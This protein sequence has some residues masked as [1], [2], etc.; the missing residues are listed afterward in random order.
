[1]HL[2]FSFS[3]LVIGIMP[4]FH[5][6]CTANK[7]HCNLI[8]FIYLVKENRNCDNSNVSNDL[9]RIFHVAKKFFKK[10]KQ[11]LGY[12]NPHEMPNVKQISN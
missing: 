8:C 10:V 3:L 2:N 4:T 5:S 9:E 11:L 12:M 7:I 1:M 6:F